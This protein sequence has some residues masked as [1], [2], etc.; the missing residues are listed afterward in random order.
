MAD[1]LTIS[2]DAA[3]LE[4]LGARSIV[5]V[6][7]MG[8]GKTS[9]GKRL[10]NRLGIGFVDADVA[11]ETAAGMSI[12]EIFVARGEPDFRAGERRVIARLLTQGRQVL[13][14][15]GGAFMNGDT[16][17]GIAAQGISVWLKADH[18]VLMRRVRKRANRPLLQTED[19]DATMRALLAVREPVYALADIMILSRDEPHDS[20]VSDVVAALNHWLLHEEIKA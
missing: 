20:V 12:P 4:K 19:P 3:L 7:M 14:T 13:A 9:V 2:D 16:R 5:L 15:G 10:A 11:I 17:A 1:D 6:G 18:E 8:S